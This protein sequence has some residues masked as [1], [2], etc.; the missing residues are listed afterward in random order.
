M[1]DTGVYVVGDS[2]GTL[3]SQVRLG[4]QDGFVRKYDPNGA[5][6]WTRQ[7]G[8][9][10]DDCAVA[11]AADAAGVYVAGYTFGALPGQAASGAADAF[12]RRYDSAGVELWT[13]QFGTTGGDYA[14]GL[15]TDGSGAYVAGYTSGTLP[16]QASAGGWSDAFVRRYDATGSEVWTRQFG[17]AADDYAYGTAADPSGVYVVGYTHGTFPGQISAGGW[18]DAFVCRFDAEGN[19][20]WTR[21]FGTAG[22]DYA[23]GVASDA[24]GADVVGQTEGILAGD[25][26]RGGT[27]AFVRRYDASGGE[28]WTRQFGG[29]GPAAEGAQ[30]A[31][32]DGNVYVVG[33]TSGA[34]PGQT[35]AGGLDVFV[36]KYDAAGN[37]LW[38]R[39]FGTA[40]DERANGVAVDASGVYVAGYTYGTLNSASV[41][42]SDAFLR[43]YDLNGNELWTR[44]F[45]TPSSDIVQGVDLD[46]SGVYVAGYTNGT[47][48]G[49]ACSG[50]SDAFLRKYDLN[51]A[52]LWT[53]QFGT[54]D[55]DQAFGVAACISGVYVAGQTYGVFAGDA[56]AG[57][58]DAFV[59]RFDAAGNIVW[60]RQFGTASSDYAYGVAADATGVYVVGSTW[61]AFSGHTS[62][63]WD[64]AYVRKFAASGDAL[65]TRQFGT[66]TSDVA[67]GVTADGSGACV[68]GQTYGRLPDQISAGGADVFVRGYDG[69]GNAVW[70]RQFGTAENDSANGV[71][72]SISGLY[73]VGHTYGTLPNQTGAGSADVFVAKI[74]TNRPPAALPG[75]PYTCPE[76]S[77]C[78]FDGSG[79]TDP[80]PGDSIV[81]Y[82]WD[83]DYDGLTFTVDASGP[84]LTHPTRTYPDG[85]A[86]K[87][88]ALRVTDA[89]G[90]SA[91]ATA[92]VTVQNV[93]PGVSAGPD[94]TLDEGGTFTSSG[95]FT[96]PGAESWTATVDYADGSGVQTLPLNADKTFALSRTYADNGTYRVTVRVD[97]GDG[98]IGTATVLVT[99][100]NVPPLVAIEGAPA[101]VPEGTAISLTSTVTDPGT[102]DT[103]TYAWSVTK[104]GS[105]YASGTDPALAFTPDDNG[106]YVV[107][108]VVTDD[109]GGSGSDS[110]SISVTNVD[111]ALTGVSVAPSTIA[112]NES[113]ALSGSIADPG[114]ADI[115]TLVIDWGDGSAAQT[116][117][118][119]SGPFSVSH[120]YRDD[121]PTAT[122]AD[123]NAIRVTVTD[124]DGGSATGSA[125]VMVQNVA[126]AARING[127]VAGFYASVGKPVSFAGAFVDPSTAD[128]HE[129]RW[130]FS[131]SPAG[132]GRVVEAAGTIDP[133]ARSVSLVH[134]FAEPGVYAVRLDVADDDRGAGTADAVGGLPAYVAI[135]DQNGGWVTGS[136]W[137]TSPAGAYAA[138]PSLTGG[139][140]F[141]INARYR[142][143]D[144]TPTGPFSFQLAV[145]NLNFASDSYQWLVVDGAR[146]QFKGTGK[147]N[148]AGSYGFMAVV[149]DGR[150]DGGGDK[151]RVRIWD[152]A[153]GAIVYDNQMG[154]PEAGDAATAIGGGGIVIH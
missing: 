133:A 151:I 14:N 96:D 27:D 108:L 83:F 148:G 80:D 63:G 2:Y 137:V 141:G 152:G 36:R 114:A 140:T 54:A 75:G 111:P 7:F 48:P 22:D 60:T 19:G 101:T 145:A 43:K 154:A 120:L 109:D 100:R 59:C 61:G 17:T 125:E 128:A 81:L 58:L 31:D 105:L 70:T 99:V 103:F 77:P 93:V 47:L 121:N 64:D 44:Q 41:G 10:D 16:G 26:A 126:P 65:W 102:L 29:Q 132:G 46:T 56:G 119:S 9:S 53:R 38:T 13:R 87:T 50:G 30:A 34:L 21:Q 134:A 11:V 144:V 8:T 32:A 97:D 91:I 130:T 135:Y 69:S 37:E 138:D 82:E 131:T 89:H 28:V 98:G 12:V 68:V 49:Q 5:E 124:D 104:D 72:A 66:S 106:S 107:T 146:A 18:Y 118:W 62:A 20:V 136:G 39:Q 115:L 94:Q 149:I 51:G 67:Q 142:K 122:P 123:A 110:E 1:A 113:V 95:A 33:Y 42:G 52:E 76:G 150:L 74:R 127:P 35:G 23:N 117:P 153:S 112:E 86:S 57:S 24:A 90:A 55:Y 147:I 40:S 84:A 79:S 88:V 71:V 4:Y 73:V 6:L 85:P 92:P 129:A 143:Q 3:P 45:G 78:A 25:A 139:A 116:V 15:T